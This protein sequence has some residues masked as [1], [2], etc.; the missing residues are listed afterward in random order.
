MN[1]HE[2]QEQDQMRET[3]C[4]YFR[5][6]ADL[7]ERKINQHLKPEAQKSRQHVG[8]WPACWMGKGRVCQK[9]DLPDIMMQTPTHQRCSTARGWGSRVMLPWG[10]FA[11]VG[12]TRAFFL[13]F[14]GLN[15]EEN[16]TLNV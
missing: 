7:L 9:V 10:N 13:H 8:R 16:I 2:N 14:I 6:I 3:E 4:V 1:M 11:I 15:F 5:D 12:L